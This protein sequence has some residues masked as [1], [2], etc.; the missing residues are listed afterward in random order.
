MA[1]LP[2]ALAG[3][4]HR[5]LGVEGIVPIHG[6]LHRR[7][8]RTPSSAGASAVG[9]GSRLR[10]ARD[11]DAAAWGPQFQGAVEDL[12]AP[13]SAVNGVEDVFEELAVDAG[14]DGLGGLIRVN[15]QGERIG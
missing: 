15:G 12:V 13:E 14:A 3:K 1:E 6:R 11:P 10:P 4:A 9:A 5:D 7:R 2:P 8:R